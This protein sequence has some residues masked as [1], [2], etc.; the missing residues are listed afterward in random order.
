MAVGR[1]GFAARA[2]SAY[3]VRRTRGAAFFTSRRILGEL[4]VVVKRFPGRAAPEG[5]PIFVLVHG[6][7]VSSRYFQPAAAEL[8]R[9]GEVYLVD[10]PGHGASPKPRPLRRVSITDN[11]A[12]LGGLIAE[13]GAPRVVLVGHSMG[14]QVV[15]RLAV[16]HPGVVDRVVLMAP[17]LDPALR[18]LPRSIGR[19][20]HDGLREPLVANLIAISDY[21]L[22]CGLRYGLLQ[23]PN[24]LE[25]RPEDYLPRLCAPTLVLRGDRDPIVG[26]DWAQ[27]VAALVPG[28]SLAEVR[29]PH[30]IMFTD[31]VNVAR[32]IAEHAA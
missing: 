1:R 16:D 14:A 20:L 29:G 19:L 25:D 7:G 6:L 2:E 23:L 12:V 8:S 31:P 24:V 26:H 11:A 28:A 10:L 32:E 18:T 22:R 21:L 27:R 30:V 3:R 13:A 4:C 5:S 17:T 9:H 15:A